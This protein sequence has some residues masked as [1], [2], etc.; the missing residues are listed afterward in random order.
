MRLGAVSKYITTKGRA[1]YRKLHKF[2]SLRSSGEIVHMYIYMKTPKNKLNAVRSNKF[3]RGGTSIKPSVVRKKER[4]R[5][6]LDF[7]F[8]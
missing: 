6:F 2:Y 7:K 3:L 4:S 5:Q 8:I 1:E